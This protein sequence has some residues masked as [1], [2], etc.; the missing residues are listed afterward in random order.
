MWFWAVPPP[1]ESFS[2]AIT[3]MEKGAERDGP[4]VRST[5]YSCR[6]PWFNSQYLHGRSQPSKTP[7]QG[8]P[9]T[10]SDFL[11]YQAHQWCID[12][13]TIETPINNFLIKRLWKPMRRQL[14]RKAETDQGSPEML[15]EGGHLL[16]RR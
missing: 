6:G 12:M 1:S 10:T 11:Q 9:S 8:E 2:T 14:E 16:P 7:V 13:H 4:V 5:N 3:N 15:G